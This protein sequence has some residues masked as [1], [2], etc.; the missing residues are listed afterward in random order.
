M[1]QD[2][3]W[4]AGDILRIGLDDNNLTIRK[5][6]CQLSQTC[7]AVYLQRLTF[8]VIFP[9]YHIIVRLIIIM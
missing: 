9:N 4:K 3:D 7:F 5:D 1:I 6:N 2:L 8:G